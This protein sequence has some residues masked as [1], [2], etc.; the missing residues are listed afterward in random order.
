VSTN[1]VRSAIEGIECEPSSEFLSTLRA[2]L[3]AINGWQT[4]GQWHE[5]GGFGYSVTWRPSD[6]V[7]LSHGG[8]VG[9]E[10][11]ASGVRFR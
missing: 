2:E 5:A 3:W 1:P 8:Y 4:F 9:P 10:L 6:R 7:S 11:S